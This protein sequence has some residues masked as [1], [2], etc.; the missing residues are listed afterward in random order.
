MKFVILISLINLVLGDH[1]Y[2]TKH[3]GLGHTHGVWKMSDGRYTDHD[4]HKKVTR[5]GYYKY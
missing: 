4:Y 2:Q 1:W 3:D 5:R